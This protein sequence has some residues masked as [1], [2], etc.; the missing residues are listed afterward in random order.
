[1]ATLAPHFRRS[2]NS[3]L[4]ESKVTWRIPPMD[5]AAQI[6]SRL[7]TAGAVRRIELPELDHPAVREEVEKRLGHC[8]FVLASSAYS[9]HYAIRLGADADNS[10]LDKPSN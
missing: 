8:G 7:I 6:C 5:D 9:D 2:Q 3:L 10:V 4:A 1:M